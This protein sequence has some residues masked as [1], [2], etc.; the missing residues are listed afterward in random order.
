MPLGAAGASVPASLATVGALLPAS[1]LGATGALLPGSGLGAAGASVAASALA[2]VGALLAASS[3]GA[4][5]AWLPASGFGAVGALLAS[6][7]KSSLSWNL[8]LGV[9]GA[10]DSEAGA[11]PGF[12]GRA[13]TTPTEKTIK[14]VASCCY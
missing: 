12:G 1:S 14:S 11:L 9:A 4:K 8:P 7:F 3:L 6:I 2:T 13:K 10:L 5:G